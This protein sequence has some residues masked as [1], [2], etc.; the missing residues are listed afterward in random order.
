[1]SLETEIFARISGYSGMAALVGT[2]IYPV[3][4]PQNAV[5]PYVIFT[6]LSEIDVTVAMGTDGGIYR[7]RLQID[8]Y[9]QKHAEAG[10]VLAIR[11]LVRASLKRYSGG[12][13]HDIYEDNGGLR[14]FVTDPDLYR[15]TMDYIVLHS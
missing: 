3:Q 2:R 9:G 4:A 15:I 10:G 14:S 11:D 6:V 13:I 1:M 8:I 7:T 5:H 12:N